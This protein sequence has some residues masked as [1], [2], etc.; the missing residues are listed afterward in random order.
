MREGF[1]DYETV[2]MSVHGDSK[3]YGDDTIRIVSDPGGYRGDAY[4]QEGVDR[5]GD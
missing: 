1:Q 5:V 3:T 2:V 4:K